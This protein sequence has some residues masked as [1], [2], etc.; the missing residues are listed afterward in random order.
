M[1]P[2]SG[3]GLALCRRIVDNHNG[4]LYAVSVPGE[5]TTFHL[6]LPDQQEHNSA[7][8]TRLSWASD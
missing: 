5:G 2:G 3:I 7:S 4:S 1:Y 8:P 6:I